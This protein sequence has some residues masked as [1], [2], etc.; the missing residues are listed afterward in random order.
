MGDQPDDLLESAV[1]TADLGV[2]EWDVRTDRVR[3][4]NR[5]CE[6]YNIDPCE[7]ERHGE[8]W[9]SM[10][11]PEDRVSARREFD[12]HVAGRRERYEAEYR[13]QTLSGGWRWIRNRAYVIRSPEDGREERMVGAC[14]DVDERKRTELALGRT[15]LKLE[16]LAAAAPIWM[17][18]TDADG[19][20]EFVNRPMQC[21]A[22]DPVVGRNIVSL[23]AEPAEA[24]RIDEF[25]RAL[26]KGRDAQTHT[27]M[28]EDGRALTTWA[29]PILEAGRVVGIAS[30]TADV[31][32]RQNRERELLAAVNREQRRFGRDLHDGLGQELTG[33]A[34]LVK[35]LSNRAGREAPA[36]VANLEEILSHVT[37]A[38]ATTRTVARGVSPVAREH[39]GLAHALKDLA[40]HWREV[41]GA[42]V[43]CRVEG[44]EA[45]EIEPMLADNLYHI[46]QEALTNAM[47]HSG[48]NEIVIELRQSAQRLSL[49]VSD[50]GCGIKPA[51]DRGTGLGLT[52]MR[53]RA[54]LAGAQLKVEARAGGGTRLECHYKWPRRR[55]S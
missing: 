34:L 31:S 1:W 27:M 3:W 17:V 41:Q 42:N 19:M 11:H 21:L 7:G 25:R 37:A 39:G 26:I 54:E 53:G 36:L 16:A 51:A 6:C 24:A 15:Q 13:I 9:R 18:L 4:L 33:I 8:R 50:D 29:Q 2:Y 14:V 35:S 5:W 43:Q 10:V 32:E 55:P 40:R 46:A 47:R 20:I 23:F 38:I 48:A 22:L 45:R 49:T 30:V 12:E 44:G 28:L 52:I